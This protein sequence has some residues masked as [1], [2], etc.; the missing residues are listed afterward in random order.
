MTCQCQPPCPEGR[1]FAD[2]YFGQL[3]DPV[4]KIN[5]DHVFPYRD[6]DCVFVEQGGEKYQ[7]VGVWGS[8]GNKLVQLVRV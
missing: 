5:D 7:I 4:V 2:V 1:S 6:G 3:G 8:W